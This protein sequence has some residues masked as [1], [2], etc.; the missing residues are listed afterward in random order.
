M[1]LE[2]SFPAPGASTGA[3][4][5]GSEPEVGGFSG[6]GPSEQQFGD[7][8]REEV[9]GRG[10][11][12][13]VYRALNTTFN[14]TVALKVW[15]EE[16][17]AYG[18]KRFLVECSAHQ[19]LAGHPNIVSFLWASARLGEA[20]WLATELCDQSMADRLRAGSMEVPDAL[21]LADDVLA[22]LE[23]IHRSGH[24]HRDVK[25]QNVLLKEGRAK[26][27]D[28]GMSMHLNS[29]TQHAFAGT[30]LYLA[31]E[32]ARGQQPTVKSDIYAAAI[33]LAELFGDPAPPGVE[34]LLTRASSVNPSDR[35]RSAIEFRQ[36]M[37]GLCQHG[38]LRNETVEPPFGEDPYA[39]LWDI[40]SSPHSH[41]H[42][43]P[44]SSLTPSG[45]DRAATMK[46]MDLRSKAPR[47]PPMWQAGP[48]TA[49][50][51]LA[52]TAPA[53]QASPTSRSRPRRHLTVFMAAV[54]A[55]VGI[56]A[57]AVAV[58]NREAL[59][60]RFTGKP[61]QAETAPLHSVVRGASIAVP[62]TAAPTV[63]DAGNPTSFEADHM[64]DGDRVT[65]W[66]MDGDGSGE[67]VRILLR[68]QFTVTQVGLTNGYTKHD[69]KDGTNRYLQE[70]RIISV[71]WQFPNGTTLTQKLDDGVW[72]LQMIAVPAVTTDSVTLHLLAT[73][74]PGDEAFDYTAISELDVVG[75]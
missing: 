56:A 67:S 13:T 7:F 4:A 1:N 22:G 57:L 49:V 23:A 62:E 74:P 20:P 10:G 36:S 65:A 18:R 29:S 32:L 25:P 50:L 51:P 47:I 72:R 73:T 9:I 71:S 35:P 15:H 54:L 2:N 69:P 70:R 17:D 27:C 75:R 28:L 21:Q 26:L 48:E 3:Q 60:E 63:D 5:S 52:R 30:G 66:R 33:T 55:V 45:L 37:R 59:W 8:V 43:P 34:K 19:R 41:G 12:A 44:N 14:G 46:P 11:S 24:V 68:H 40:R 39:R 64:L 16:L 6:V 53:S 42:A 38:Q 61:A 58:V 31:P